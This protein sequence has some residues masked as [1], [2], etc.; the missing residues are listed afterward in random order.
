MSTRRTTILVLSVDE[1]PYLEHCL[2]AA[3]AQPDSEVVVID[4]ACTDRTRT[5]CEEHGVRVVGLRERVSYAAAMNAGLAATSGPAVLVLNADCVLDPGFLAAA[6]P[7][8]EDP[9][10]GSVAPRLIRSTSMEPA[11]RLDVLDAAGMTIDRRRKNSLVAHG[12]PASSR[13][14]QGEAFGGDGA[15]VLYRREVLDACAVG[16]EVFDEDMAL[17]ATDA[18]LAWRARTLGWRCVYEPRAV[19]WHKR[20]YSPTTRGALPA[21]H[22]T[23]QFRNRLLMVVKNDTPGALLRDLPFWLTWEV[24]AFGHALLR[25]RTLLRGYVDFWRLAPRARR[26]RAILRERRGGRASAPVP[27]GLRPPRS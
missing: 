11:D 9:A 17:W 5:V 21:E 6:A 27:F 1:A 24:L 7:R 10:V 22:R 19:G 20:F 14:T 4:N 13:T 25:E 12:E 2:P 18:D 15:C 23:L 3:V 16:K 8:L 26:R